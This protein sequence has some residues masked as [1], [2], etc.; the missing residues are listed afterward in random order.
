[1]IFRF[2]GFLVL[3]TDSGARKLFLCSVGLAIKIHP[4]KNNPSQNQPDKIHPVQNP[5]DQ[6]QPELK[7]NRVEEKFINFYSFDFL[8]YFELFLV[9]LFI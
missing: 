1:M 5:S 3:T 6:N 7:P 4:I 8:I 2:C 9:S